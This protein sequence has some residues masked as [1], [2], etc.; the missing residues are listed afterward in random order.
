M[1][2]EWQ[3]MDK[4]VERGQWWRNVES[5][6]VESSLHYEFITSINIKQILTLCQTLHWT[7]ERKL[8]TYAL[9]ASALRYYPLE[10]NKTQ[11]RGRPWYHSCTYHFLLYTVNSSLFLL[12]LALQNLEGIQINKYYNES[13][14]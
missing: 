10:H 5:C 4:A 1:D 12:I 7:L 13:T 3:I 9:N 14:E 11:T 6:C 2:Y 8:T